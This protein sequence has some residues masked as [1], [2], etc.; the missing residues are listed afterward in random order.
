MT[1]VSWIDR[2]RERFA[3]A[4]AI[5]WSGGSWTWAELADRVDATGQDLDRIGVVAGDTVAL[6]AE[7]GPA[8]ARWLHAAAVR[9]V[10]LLPL[11]ARLTPAEL[12]FQLADAGAR[13][14]LV[15]PD[16]EADRA[17]A[18]RTRDAAR[19]I[20]PL[21]DTGA[22]DVAAS[23]FARA[24]RDDIG[25]GAPFEPE[26]TLALLY[27][28]G[29]TG[30]PKGVQ[31]PVRAFDAS[32]RASQRSVPLAVGD[33]WLVCM[34]LFH[35]GGLSILVRTAMAGARAVV[36]AGFD[37]AAVSRALEDDGVTHV[38]FVPTMLKRVLDDRGDA[39]APASLRCVLLGGGAAE[40]ALIERA[41]S[42]GYPVVP[43]YGLT[44]ACSQVATRSPDDRVEPV[45]GRLRV[46]EGLEV[47]VRDGAGVLRSASAEGE[48]C[49]R[50]ATVASGYAGHAA[51]RAIVD[52]EGWLSTGDLGRLD[53]DGRVEVI[54][55]RDD[56]I[57]SGGEN[58]YPAEVE[59]ALLT[60]ASVADAAVVAR[61]DSE[62]GARPVAF[63]VPAA[64][65]SMPASATLEAYLRA[66]LAAY[67][68]PVA[69]RSMRE[70]PRTASGKV[71]RVEL[72]ERAARD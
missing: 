36:H 27:T 34:P 13:A 62:F 50:G 60:H 3:Q 42:L 69:F 63:V 45:T 11:N 56:L 66:R 53:A 48:L 57:V 6:L 58:V 54:D 61:P 49:L 41:W 67:K 8:W 32:A 15:G 2:A 65:A 72:R 23:S 16:V 71:R 1:S 21:D 33:R 52:A 51:G 4:K 43:T 38:S 20:H 44:E 59:Q 39:P 12:A 9:G 70:L 14:C 46:L 30:R 5:T 68:V 29:T 25:K 64:G 26:R 18:L 17:G 28:S 22:L 7:N 37:P 24:P 10:T 47:G 40:P 35:V 19:P 55:R 31:L